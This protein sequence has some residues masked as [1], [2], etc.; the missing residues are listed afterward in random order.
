MELWFRNCVIKFKML[1]KHKAK[2][3]VPECKLAYVWIYFTN[4]LDLFY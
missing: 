3:C 4:Q 2:H 1:T